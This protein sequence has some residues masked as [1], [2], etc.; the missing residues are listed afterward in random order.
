MKIEELKKQ[1]ENEW[2]LVEVLEED[3]L[4]RPVEVRLIAHS[5]NR[6][7]I[8]EGL[9]KVEDNKHVATLYTGKIPEKGYAVA[10]IFYGKNRY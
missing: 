3:N 6:D 2:L 10:F 4:N 5:K 7:E 1:F 9:D 8:Y